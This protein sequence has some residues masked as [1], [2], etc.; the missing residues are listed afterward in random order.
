M[1]TAETLTPEQVASILQVNPATVY[2]ALRAGRIPGAKVGRL[3]RIPRE[4]FYREIMKVDADRREDIRD[5]DRLQ[6]LARRATR[7]RERLGRR[8][9]VFPDV[10]RLLAEDRSRQS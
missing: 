4:T 2:R 1:N 7:R 6:V 3:W 10:V 8:G 9:C 5:G